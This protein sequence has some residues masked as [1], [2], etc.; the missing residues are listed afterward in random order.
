MTT[1]RPLKFQE[2]WEW[3]VERAQVTRTEHTKGLV[4][5]NGDKLVGAVAVD[6]WTP[7]SCRMHIAVD[8]M[9][10]FK[11][12]FPEEVYGWIFNECDK[13]VI[14]GATPAHL[15]KVLRF[16]RHVGFKEVYRI[17]DGYEIGIDMVIQECRKEDCKYLRNKDGQRHSSRA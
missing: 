4:A 2:E 9:L 7:N 11:H 5:Y 15:D 6:S 3:L 17:P 8:N 14:V 12:G 10:I 13:G 16:N 1:F